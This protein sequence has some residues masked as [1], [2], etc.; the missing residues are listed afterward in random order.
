MNIALLFT[1]LN[2]AQLSFIRAQRSSVGFETRLTQRTMYRD[3]VTFHF[4]CLADRLRLIGM[5]FAMIIRLERPIDD[6]SDPR[7]QI[8][9]RS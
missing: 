1:T 3:G 7:F 2:H 4:M 5:E 9:I 6:L 8:R